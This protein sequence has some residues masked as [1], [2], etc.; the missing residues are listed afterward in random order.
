MNYKILQELISNLK[1]FEDEK[2]SQ[3][4]K[5]QDFVVFLN[6][7]YLGN[8]VSAQPSIDINAKSE[9]NNIGQL[10]AFMYRYAK[11]YIKKALEESTLLTLD[12]FGYLAAVW[13]EGDLTK[14]QVIEKN[15]HEKNT[16]MEIIKRLIAN[17]LLE[18]YDD[19]EDKRSKR[20]KITP[21]GQAELFKSFEGMLKVSQIIS[22]KL[23]SAEKIQ[24]FYLLSKLHDFHNP[25]FLTEKETSIDDLLKKYF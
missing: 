24:L 20:L 15:I 9:E 8:L 1:D 25:I 16:G 3:S 22:G 10:V 12:D 14:T 5:M 4:L 19:L 11:G 18:Q 7:K 21:L 13:Q 23:T 17:N 6:Q 2:K